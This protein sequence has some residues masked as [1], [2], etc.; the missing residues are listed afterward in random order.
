MSTFDDRE[1]AFEKKYTMD[2]DKAFRV[3]ARACKL[4][5]LWAAEK[6]GKSDAQAEAYAKEVVS[7]DFDAPGDEDV[8]LK[9]S[10]DL[11]LAGFSELDGAAVRVEL[12]RFREV[13]RAQIEKG[14]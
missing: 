7:A 12:D 10:V 1:K 2:N 6:L 5:G 13:A 3:N 8:V 4:L 9:V 11:K 14:E